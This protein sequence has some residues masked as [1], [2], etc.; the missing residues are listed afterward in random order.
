MKSFLINV[1]FGVQ[2]CLSKRCKYATILLSKQ[3]L[4]DI[5]IKIKLGIIVYYNKYVTTNISL[6]IN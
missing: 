4:Y 3:I 5:Y 1:N 6:C 2:I